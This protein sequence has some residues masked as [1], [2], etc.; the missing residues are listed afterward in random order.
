MHSFL[1][2]YSPASTWFLLLLRK[3]QNWELLQCAH[4]DASPEAVPRQCP[5]SAVSS[6][7]PGWEGIELNGLKF[8]KCSIALFLLLLKLNDGVTWLCLPRMGVC[9]GRTAPPWAGRAAPLIAFRAF[10]CIALL[11]IYYRRDIGCINN[12]S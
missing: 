10:S 12:R 11:A 9:S 8:M 7:Q 3:P 4:A 5:G 1:T 6:P 2:N